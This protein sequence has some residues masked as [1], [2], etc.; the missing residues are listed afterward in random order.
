MKKFFKVIL[1]FIIFCI[2]LLFWATNIEPN[3][4]VVKKKNIYLPSWD[5]NLDGYKI[6]VI[7]DMHIGTRNVNLKKVE[8]VINLM[9][10]Q[11]PDLVV[12]LGDFDAQAIANSKINPDKISSILNKIQT[13]QK[14]IAILGNHDYKPAGV[15]KPIL[16][17]SDIILLENDDTYI[18]YKNKKIRIVG[19]KDLWHFNP[20]AKAVIG[21]VD[22]NIPTVVLAHNPDAFVDVPKEV[23]LTLSGHTHGGELNLPFVGSA[24]VPSDYGQRFSKGYIVENNKHLYVSAGIGTLSKIRFL[25]KP[26]II[27]LKIYSQTE[28]NSIENTKV[29]KGFRKN[30]IHSYNQCNKLLRSKLK[31]D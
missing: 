1:F 3:M 24:T 23:S 4:L 5:K 28:R 15:I 27:V 18:E 2:C 30:Y 13:K 10:K 11:N 14:S 25:N 29:K 12:F 26:E 19:L 17:N 21:E 16:K 8:K 9:N 31:I 7:A 22:R 6:G 20:D